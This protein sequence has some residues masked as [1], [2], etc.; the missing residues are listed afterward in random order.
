M[1]HDGTAARH[2]KD[3]AGRY[4]EIYVPLPAAIKYYNQ[5]MGGV[6]TSDQ[7]IGYHRIVRQTKRYWK[8]LFYHLLDVSMTNAFVLRKC[9]LMEEGINL[10]TESKFRDTVILAIIKAYSA[11]NA[12]LSTNDYR[13]CHGSRAY[14]GSR[15]R[16]KVCHKRSNR[17]CPTAH[18]Y[19]HFASRYCEIAMEPGIL[20]YFMFI[21]MS[22]SD[23]SDR[24]LLRDLKCQQ[25]GEEDL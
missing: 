2:T 11:P 22:G 17:Q 14:G 13:V 15:R 10:P 21:A 9:L 8:T 24:G 20:Q 6:D 5:Y 18:F 25:K 12:P 1:V 19:H 23:L 3:R 7:L 4:S 16:C